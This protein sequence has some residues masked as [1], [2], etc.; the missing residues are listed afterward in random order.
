MLHNGI[1]LPHW[2]RCTH[3]LRRRRLRV[4]CGI[5][6]RRSTW[7]DARDGLGAFFR[8]LDAVPRAALPDFLCSVLEVNDLGGDVPA[9]PEC[10]HGVP[11]AADVDKEALP[12]GLAA[13][14]VG[15]VVHAVIDVVYDIADLL[16]PVL[17]LLI[18]SSSSCS[19]P[20]ELAEE[21]VH[22]GEL[23]VHVLDLTA[24]ATDE[25]VLLGEEAA[26]FAKQRSHGAL[27]GAH[28]ELHADSS[29]I[30]NRKDFTAEIAEQQFLP[31]RKNE[32]CQEYAWFLCTLEMNKSRKEKQ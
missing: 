27:R 5:R 12:S 17:G 10:G 18:V 30:C 2:L 19:C 23:V 20:A 29:L 13:E 8:V 11:H 15:E 1:L 3:E 26:E 28:G 21:G 22:A 7:L 32:K 9:C 14:A 31:E 24:D 4:I 6:V 25:R 16:D